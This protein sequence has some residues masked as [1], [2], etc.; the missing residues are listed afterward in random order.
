[1]DVLV[2]P[3]IKPLEQAGNTTVA[4]VDAEE[5]GRERITPV[6]LR[7]VVDRSLNPSELPVREIRTQCGRGE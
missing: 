1:M 6:T 4:T 2:A 5:H 3:L 7:P